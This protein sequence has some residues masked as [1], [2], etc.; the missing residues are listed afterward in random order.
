MS[1]RTY[2]NSIIKILRECGI[3]SVVKR[4]HEIVKKDGTNELLN[5][6]EVQRAP[7]VI[8]REIPLFCGKEDNISA[9]EYRYLYLRISAPSFVKIHFC[10][11]ARD[12]IYK[13]K[14]F[15]LIESHR[16]YIFDMALISATDKTARSD[17]F[18]WGDV[19]DFRVFFNNSSTTI[20]WSKF[21]KT[22][23][24]LADGHIPVIEV[25]DYPY[26]MHLEVTRNCNLKCYMC[27]ENRDHELKEIGINDFDC[28]ILDRLIPFMQHVAHIALFGWGESLCH[29][30]FIRFIDAVSKMKESNHSNVVK[31]FVNITTNATLL[32]KDLICN[33]IKCGLD[34]IIVS[35]DSPNRKNFNFI[36]KGA[37]FNNVIKN[38]QNLQKLKA[39]Y[40]V[41]HPK[42]TLEF[43]A[44]R[45]N[46]EELPEVLKLA[47]DLGIKRV[48]VFYVTVVTKGLEQESLYYHQEL[49]NHMFDK[50]DK[51]AQA[52]GINIVLPPRFGTYVDP[53][54]Y[55]NDVQKMFYVKAEG[56]VM[57]CCIATDV[58]IGDLHKES[59]EEIW[60]GERRRK[61]IDNLRKGVL[62]GKCKNCYKFTGNDINLRETHIK[63]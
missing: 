30:N 40:G 62:E 2:I 46:I 52:N 41:S 63:V 58:N 5:K 33:L 1:K 7:H 25:I 56:T 31:P 12:D 17:Y 15:D 4:I 61:I 35:I 3:A 6:L 37:D 16:I 38:L 50:A 19:T 57:P 22:K 43:V 29:P 14:L 60:Q 18:W 10:W 23:V 8:G 53:E 28:R 36:R 21:T 48:L 24:G 47:I 49:A 13:T 9:D 45:R 44:M 39:E 11:H 32:T 55:C 59:P 54:G 42:L 20:E 26:V 27:R 51:I 34:E